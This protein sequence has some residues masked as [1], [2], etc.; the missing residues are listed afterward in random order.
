MVIC[1]EKKVLVRVD[2]PGAHH[3]GFGRI[4]NPNISGNFGFV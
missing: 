3:L 2:S 1:C 4:I